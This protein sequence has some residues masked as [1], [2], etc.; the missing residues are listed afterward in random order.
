[1]SDKRDDD[2]EKNEYK[3]GY[4]NPPKHTQFQKGQSGNP[5][6]R[7]KGAKNIATLFDEV[8]NEKVTIKEGSKTRKVS[9]FEA[10]IQRVINAAM[11]GDTRS[12]NLVI[13][14]DKELRRFEP[15]ESD[16]R[17]GGVLVVPA[18]L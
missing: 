10:I 8:L 11:Q 14:M 16:K 1:M 5:E 7:P 12:I 3:V 13:K 15:E 9:K 4:C 2:K 17:T 6:G 18:Q